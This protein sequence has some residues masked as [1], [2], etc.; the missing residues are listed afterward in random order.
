MAVVSSVFGTKFSQKY[1]KIIPMSSDKRLPW[2]F[3]CGFAGSSSPWNSQQ[4]ETYT[5]K[6]GLPLEPKKKNE[7]QDNKPYIL[8]VLRHIRIFSSQI[9]TMM[10][11][12]TPSWSTKTTNRRCEINP[13]DIRFQSSLLLSM[14]WLSRMKMHGK[15]QLKEKV[16]K[17]LVVVW[18]TLLSVVRCLTEW[19]KQLLAL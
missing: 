19:K 3:N 18:L 8:A 5:S 10:E 15:E 12:Q 11:H 2:K 9:S 13:R 7:M 1:L 16:L 17:F 14:L 4:R 6:L